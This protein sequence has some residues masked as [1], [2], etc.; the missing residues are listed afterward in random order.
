MTRA[1]TENM[2]TMMEMRDR[3]AID[4]AVYELIALSPDDRALAVE[5]YNAIMGQGARPFWKLSIQRTGE[6]K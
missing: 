3:S 6:V 2:R 4:N 1:D 5:R